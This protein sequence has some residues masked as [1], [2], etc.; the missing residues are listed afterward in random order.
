M[1]VVQPDYYRHDSLGRKSIQIPQTQHKEL[2]KLAVDLDSSLG[3]VLETMLDM[4]IRNNFEQLKAEIQLKRERER[5]LS[6]Q[7]DT[8]DEA[9]AYL[10]TLPETLEDAHF[11]FAVGSESMV[12]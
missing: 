8:L 12:A 9:Y 7:Q 3:D 11:F 1:A 10:A 6:S 2:K 5:E 4:M